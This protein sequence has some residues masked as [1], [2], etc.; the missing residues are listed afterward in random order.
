V[1]TLLPTLDDCVTLYILGGAGE[2]VDDS[3]LICAWLWNVVKCMTETVT[4][5]IMQMILS[6]GC[7]NRILSM[8]Q[9]ELT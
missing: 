8:R 3:E 7:Y 9:I 4:M 1:R 2:C 5:N 6:T